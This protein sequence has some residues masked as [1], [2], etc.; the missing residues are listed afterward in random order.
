MF[1][2]LGN[3][4]KEKSKVRYISVRQITADG[5]KVRQKL[6][7]ILTFHPTPQVSLPV[8]AKICEEESST[9]QRITQAVSLPD[10]I[11]LNTP[12]G[13]YEMFGFYGFLE[14]AS[15]SDANYGTLSRI[16]LPED[17]LCVKEIVLSPHMYVENVVVLAVGNDMAMK[18]DMTSGNK[19][20]HKVYYSHN[21]F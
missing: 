17:D 16:P 3:I 4:T 13:L 8:N 21:C 1:E 15:Y 11:I 6:P 18:A 7:S 10:R 20:F 14:D 9:S 5:W 12:S 2:K 19:T